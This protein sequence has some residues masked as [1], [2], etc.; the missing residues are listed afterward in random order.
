MK[1]HSLLLLSL[2]IALSC[3]PTKKE[4][5]T[6]PE[7]N[8]VPV[9]TVDKNLFRSNT[10]PNIQIQVAEEF[11]Y[12]G[13]FYF[14]IIASSEE[15]PD[16]IQGKAVAAGDRYVFVRSN[17]EN[18]VEK[19]FIVQLEG[20]LPNNTFKYNYRFDQAEQIGGNR[21]RHNTWF[22]DSAEQAAQNPNNEGARTRRFLQDKG[23]TLEDDVMMARWVGLASEDRKYEIILFYME[24]MEGSIGHSLEAFEALP[25]EEQARIEAKFVERARKGFS[26]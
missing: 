24:M 26:M 6:S 17:E 2:L 5:P 15:Y 14:E 21:Y 3:T 20:F 4:S 11:D 8:M 19:L 23:F 9:R 13:S 22:Y 1:K 25:E 7:E 18:K 16:S 12:V 10:L